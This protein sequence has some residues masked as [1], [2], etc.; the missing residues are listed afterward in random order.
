MHDCLL[1]YVCTSFG[2]VLLLNEYLSGG[3]FDLK[4]LMRR[5]A[6]M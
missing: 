1:N 5:Y 2:F 4:L 3:D 6:T